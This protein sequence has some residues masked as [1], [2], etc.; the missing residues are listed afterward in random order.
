MNPDL[1]LTFVMKWKDLKVYFSLK[2]TKWMLHMEKVYHRDQPNKYLNLW[3]SHLHM[4]S[5][6]PCV[7]FPLEWAAELD[8]FSIQNYY[9]S[10]NNQR[11]SR[12]QV[13]HEIRQIVKI[14]R[15]C[16]DFFLHTIL[17]WRTYQGVI[18][19]HTHTKIYHDNESCIVL[20]SSKW[21]K[22]I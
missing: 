21:N 10:N 4:S 2:D 12:T 6:L 13:G 16:S 18:K 17:K 14:V 5:T 15:F 7:L 20:F 19:T 3:P 1:H 9:Q 22:N 8:T 11:R